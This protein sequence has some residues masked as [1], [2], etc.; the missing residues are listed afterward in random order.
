MKELLYLLRGMYLF[1]HSAHHLVKG[2]P[3]HSDHGFF[4]DV[5][6]DIEGDYDDVA[7]RI[8]GLYGEEHLKLQDVV[9]GAMNKI[10]DAPSVGV[11]DNKVFYDYQ[12]KLDERLKTLI[13]QIIA[14]GVSPGVEQ[15]I[16]EIANKAEMRCYK[17]KQR[18]K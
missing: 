17:V 10:A 15:L 4:G 18:M 3:F 7:E 5:Y 13:K 2:T 8:I 11:S 9:S 14:T 6:N 1:A 16:G 12:Y